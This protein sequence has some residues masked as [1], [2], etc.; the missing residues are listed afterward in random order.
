MVGYKGGQ[1]KTACI[2]WFNPCIRSLFFYFFPHEKQSLVW[3]LLLCK[4][5]LI[6]ESVLVASVV[7]SL[8]VPDKG[9]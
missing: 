7:V 4:P 1:G 6:S 8:L 3:K 5:E 9:I 2:L